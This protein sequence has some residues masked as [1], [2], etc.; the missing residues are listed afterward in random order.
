MKVKNLLFIIIL[1][2]IA[3]CNYPLVNSPINSLPLLTQDPNNISPAYIKKIEEYNNILA[4]SLIPV[5]IMEQN[6]LPE[7]LR[8]DLKIDLIGELYGLHVIN[9]QNSTLP[10]EFIFI[11][12]DNSPET[13]ITTFFH[14]YQHYQCRKTKCYCVRTN[15]LP[16]DEQLVLTI[17]REKHAI[18]GALRRSLETK[19]T[20]LILNSFLSTTH[21]ALYEVNCIYKMAAIS[22]ASG[23]L[24]KEVI[25]FVSDL[26]KGKLKKVR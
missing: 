2:I 23:D 25:I 22:V 4:T 7:D 13:I 6:D 18:E 9:N 5:F 16:P 20:D 24:W 19:N 1:L 26:E 14:E 3:G 12:I 8:T 17:L 21:F 10:D 15:F 11:N